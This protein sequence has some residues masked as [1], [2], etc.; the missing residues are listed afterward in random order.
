MRDEMRTSRLSRR[1]LGR[2]LGAFAG[3]AL[4]PAS[5]AATLV[6]TPRQVE[7][8]FYPV[9]AR[10]ES[11][12][13]LTLLDGHSEP[14]TGEVILVRGR[15]VDTHGQALDGAVVDVW[16]A[17]HFGRYDHPR[18]RSEAPVDPNFQGR[19][20]VH[21]GS[22]GSYG[23]KTVKPG[24]YYQGRPGDSPQRCRHIHFKVSAPGVPM[25]VTQ[26]YFEGDPLIGQD[27]V[28][29]RVPQDLRRL[30]IAKPVVDSA[31]GLSVYRF[32]IVLDV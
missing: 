1:A 32:D 7:G 20:V 17:N 31:S 22:N 14:A 2:H 12:L 9:D 23:F 8:P 30:L 15:V 16:Q 29:A 24:A 19:A 28:I 10:S 26:M 25:L 27:T 6:A 18:D 21:A 5:L 13:D 11:D 3:A 4:M